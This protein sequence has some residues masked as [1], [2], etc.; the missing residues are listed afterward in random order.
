MAG[1]DGTS[2]LHRL[3]ERGVIR[4]AASYAVNINAY[5]AFL[6]G[7][8]LLANS[9]VVDAKEAI[10][11]LEQAL[12]LN[13]GFAAA[14]VNLPRA[15]LFVAEFEV[16]EDR[17]LRFETALRRGQTLV[18]KALALD[19]ENGDAHLQRAQLAAFYDLATAEADYRRGL[20]LSPNAAEGH[21]GL[22]AVLYATPSRRD[23]ALRL[24]DRARRLN[25]LE[26][27]HDVTKSVFLFDELSD[28]EGAV[29]CCATSWREIR[30]MSRRS[31]AC[32]R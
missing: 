21:A 2:W 6:Q 7:R 24:L 26:P 10:E 13:P 19:L 20:E 30:T 9:R 11:S 5:L 16:T 27:A 29:S 25:P 28:I 8:A 31:R 22:A 17:Q 4:V 18:D 32:A 3:R 1:A 14:Y 23:E 12:R 15:G